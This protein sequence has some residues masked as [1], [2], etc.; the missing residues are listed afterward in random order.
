M[1]LLG[2]QMLPV[3][4]F[5]NQKHMHVQMVKILHVFMCKLH[6]LGLQTLKV[7]TDTSSKSKEDNSIWLGKG[8]GSLY[9]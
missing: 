7:G 1:G 3:S 2:T 5:L 4:L 6:L 9:S 8:N